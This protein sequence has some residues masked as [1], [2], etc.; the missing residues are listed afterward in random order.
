VL[1]FSFP[2]LFFNGTLI[3]LDVC[4]PYFA[5]TGGHRWLCES[6]MLLLNLLI[7]CYYFG[8]ILNI[9]SLG[10]FYLYIYIQCA[11]LVFF[12]IGMKVKIKKKAKIN[13]LCAVES[14]MNPIF[15]PSFSY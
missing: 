9:Q 8:A 13:Y 10:K 3:V 1:N 12:A 14:Y 6:H 5:E 2:D 11:F 15:F 7:Y 4:S